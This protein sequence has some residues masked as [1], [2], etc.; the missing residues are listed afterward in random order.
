MYKIRSMQND[1]EFTLNCWVNCTEL[2]NNQM[3]EEFCLFVR[4]SLDIRAMWIEFDKR[5]SCARLKNK[6]FFFLLAAKF[7]A[8]DG[9]AAKGLRS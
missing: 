3:E 9:V 4:L 1:N 8:K 7:A 5:V 6:S 2:S